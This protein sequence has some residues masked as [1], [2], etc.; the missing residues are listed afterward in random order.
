MTQENNLYNLM[1]QLTQ[2][3]KSLWR[4]QNN[5]QTDANGNEELSTFWT[6]LAADKEQHIQ[7]LKELIKKQM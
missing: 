7:E 3:A 1:T 2:E 6:K 5:Y 4:I